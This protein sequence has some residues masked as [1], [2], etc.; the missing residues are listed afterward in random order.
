MVESPTRPGR[1][2]ADQREHI[3]GLLASQASRAMKHTSSGHDYDKV[4]ADYFIAKG[5]IDASATD[6]AAMQALNRFTLTHCITDAAAKTG[7][8]NA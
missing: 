2:S 3:K 8:E 1:I 6:V 5:R 4:M 7:G